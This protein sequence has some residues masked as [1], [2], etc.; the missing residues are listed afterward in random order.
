MVEVPAPRPG[1]GEIVVDVTAAGVNFLDIYFRTGHYEKPMPFTPG[2]E[3][4]GAINAI[5]NGVRGFSVGDR[6]AWAQCN[7]SYA[8]Q[9]VMQAAQAV[10]V[11]DTIS[12]EMAA[13]GL[14]HGMAARY[15]TTSTYKVG[16]GDTVL[17]Q[18]GTGGMRLLVVQLAK[19]KGARVFVTTARKDLAQLAFASGADAVISYARQNVAAEVR[20]LTDGEGVDVVY[21]G[22]GRVTFDASLACLR[23]RGT[24][25]IMSEL[26]GPVPPIDPARLTTGSFFLTRPVLGHHIERREDLE[27]SARDVFTWIRDGTLS[28][29]TGQLHPLQNAPDAHR[30]LEARRD[31][32]KPVLLPHA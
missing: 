14:L 31:T 22:L 8:E 32:G 11:P 26:T 20:R 18:G 12:D 4:C 1:P 24:L 2:I 21:D 9:I 16:P 3:G 19:S 7:G 30:E 15:L 28:V 29:R 5:G 6:V 25:V 10:V 17:V 23:P 13:A 27:A